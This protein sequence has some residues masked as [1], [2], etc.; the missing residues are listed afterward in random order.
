MFTFLSTLI[1]WEY[2][3]QL[4]NKL[5]SSSFKWVVKYIL[6]LDKLKGEGRLFWN[7]E[8]HLSH[9]GSEYCYYDKSV[10]H[11]IST[12]GNREHPANFQN[13]SVSSPLNWVSGFF[14]FLSKLKGRGKPF[15]RCARIGTA[16]LDSPQEYLVVIRDE[17]VSPSV[18]FEI[19]L[20]LLCFFMPP[21]K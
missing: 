11:P 18:K 5:V 12:R 19:T 7:G 17:K 13:K 21:Y 1:V 3:C 4:Q 14:L 8:K 15:L 6:F 2:E 20:T 10:H 9:V 16:L